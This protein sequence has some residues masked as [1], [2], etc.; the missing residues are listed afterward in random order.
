MHGWAGVLTFDV[1]IYKLRIRPGRRR[2]FCVRWR[3]AGRDH[4]ESYQFEAR[5]RMGVVPS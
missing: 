5:R 1:R 4:S 3:V 2:P